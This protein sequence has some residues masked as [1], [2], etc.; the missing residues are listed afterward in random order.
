MHFKP[1]FLITHNL[2]D[3]QVLLVALLLTWTLVMSIPN[4]NLINNLQTGHYSKIVYSMLSETFA[5]SAIHVGR[6]HKE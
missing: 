6:C 1:R 4:P 5:N 2:F 3:K